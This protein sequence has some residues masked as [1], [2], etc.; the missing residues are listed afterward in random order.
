MAGSTY[1]VGIDF[2]PKDNLSPTLKRFHKDLHSLEKRV[3]SLKPAFE[4]LGGTSLK[5]FLAEASA[6]AQI[7]DRLRGSLKL[8]E[9]QARV[10]KILADTDNKRLLTAERLNQVRARTASIEQRAAR[11]EEASA[12]RQERNADRLSRQAERDMQRRQRGIERLARQE[13]MAAQRRQRAAER[14]ERAEWRRQKAIANGIERM[15]RMQR[16]IDD[17]ARHSMQTNDVARLQHMRDAYLPTAGNRI[18]G[19]MALARGGASVLGGM[20]SLGHDE[21]VHH[22]QK[23]E[24]ALGQMNLSKHDTEAAMK[25]AERVRQ[26]VRGLDAAGAIDVIKDLINITGSVHEATSGPLANKLAKF[27]VSNKVAYGLS[28]QQGYQAI[29]A[30]ELISPNRKGMTDHD[31]EMALSS[32]MD[33]INRVMAGSG[34][35]IKPSDILGFAK[36]AQ[37][38]RM[39]LSDHGLMNLM[40]IVQEMGGQKTGTALMSLMQNLANGRTT[41]A[42]ANAMMDLGLLNRKMVDYDKNGRVKRV[43]PGAVVDTDQLRSDPLAWVEQKLMPLAKGKDIKQVDSL[44][45]SIITNRTASG[46]VMT[47]IG[48]NSRINKDAGL[49]RGSRDVAQTDAAQQDGNYLRAELNYEVAMSNLRV[50]MS[51][52]VLPALTVF[53]N[54]FADVIER[55]NTFME[56]HPTAAKML[57]GG[58]VAAGGAAVIGG[59]AMAVG[60]AVTAFRAMR[61]IAAMDGVGAAAASRVAG[62]MAASSAFSQAGT[63]IGGRLM[64]TMQTPILSGANSLAFKFGATFGAVAAAELGWRIGRAIGEIQLPNGKTVDTVIQDGLLGGADVDKGMDDHT[65]GLVAR[66]KVLRGQTGVMA[67]NYNP[68]L[69]GRIQLRDPVPSKT[70]IPVQINSP[71]TV[72]VSATQPG[73]VRRA[74]DSAV[75]KIGQNAEVAWQTRRPATSTSMTGAANG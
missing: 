26:E 56:K 17:N 40:P 59:G 32:R 24:T 73:D 41:T 21:G 75:R 10:T 70:T 74:V 9:S 62:D 61:T 31:K 65:K 1:K 69:P 34:G 18:A 15:E 37:S 72:Q 66:N 63:T 27:R 67:P 60:G 50:K 14:A 25:A 52:H 16:R 51:K 20:L 54:K 28:D 64:A 71:V 42:S 6:L 8:S 3:R 35:K 33:L 23:E 22:F 43:K 45:N 36:N 57:A 4:A 44:I 5:T 58:S 39:S 30:A 19:G 2:S 47:M 46:L 38:S 29:Q 7:N 12:R 49:Y 68:G 13:E 53:V 48:Q 11:A 55:L